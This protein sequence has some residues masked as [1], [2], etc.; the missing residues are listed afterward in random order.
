MVAA[1]A[2]KS[3]KGTWTL[4]VRDAAAQDFGLL[5]SFSLGLSFPH[6]DRSPRIV[7]PKVTKKKRKK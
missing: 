1:F 4:R 6:P 7:E 2:G 3:C 5:V